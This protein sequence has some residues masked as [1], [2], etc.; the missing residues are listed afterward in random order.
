[1][2]EIKPTYVTF[3]QAKWLKE[4][5][6]DED[7]S[8]MYKVQCIWGFGFMQYKNSQIHKNSFDTTAPEQWQVVEWLRVKHSIILFALPDNEEDF[9]DTQKVLY[10]PVVY[11]ATKGLY[12]L[13]KELLRGKEDKSINYFNSPQEAYS[14]AFDYILNKGIIK[15]KR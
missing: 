10:T 12:N 2:E 8:K 5:G 15:L 11:R 7:C 6:F 9:I 4:K 13:Y 14:A 3:E 1:M